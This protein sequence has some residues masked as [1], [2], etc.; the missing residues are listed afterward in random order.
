MFIPRWIYLPSNPDV[1]VFTCIHAWSCKGSLAKF[2]GPGNFRKA[3][4]PRSVG[5]REANSTTLRIIGPSNTGYFEDPT[6]AIQVQTPF[7]WR[8]LPIL[9]GTKKNTRDP[10]A[11]SSAM[12]RHYWLGLLK[13][14]PPLSQVH[15]PP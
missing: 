3:L 7:H 4:A 10:S 11:I 2:F 1:K 12:P 13:E 5:S 8:V 6:L 14:T 15:H 9:R